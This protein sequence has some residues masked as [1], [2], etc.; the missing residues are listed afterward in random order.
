MIL[1]QSTMKELAPFLAVALMLCVAAVC[2]DRRRQLFWGRSLGLRLLPL[3]V[4]SGMAR[5]FV[6]ERIVLAEQKQALEEESTY[7]VGEI[8]GI[9]EKESW[10]VLLLR[11]VG[12]EA[13]K[14]RYLQVYAERADAAEKSETGLAGQPVGQVA[15]KEQTSGRMPQSDHPDQTEYRIGDVVRVWGEFTQFQPASNPGEFDYASYYRGQ[16][17]IWRVFA[18]AVRK[19]E[20]GEGLSYVLPNGILRVRIWAA[21][22][23]RLLAGEEDGSIFAAM[24]LGDKSGMSE[25]IRD[26]YQKNGIAHLLAVSGLH[27]SLVSMAAYGLLRK[28]GAGYGRAAVAGGVVLI[29]YSILTGASPSVIRALIMTLC[30]FLAAW[31]GRTYDLLSAMGLSA[32]ML[33][34]HSPYLI[35]QAGV[36]L[37]FA[38]IGGIGLAKEL[39]EWGAVWAEKGTESEKTLLFGA[40][41]EGAQ[42]WEQTLRLTLCMQLVSLPVVLW[43]FFSYPLYGIFLNLLV[44]PLTGIIVGSGAGSLLASLFAIRAGTF[45]TGGGRAV[46]AWYEICCRWFLRLPG[47]SLL[48]G[49]PELSERFASRFGQDLADRLEF[50]TING[51]CARVI[52]YY[53]RKTARTA[54]SLLTDEKRIS[55]ILS[56][57]Y[58]KTERV[59]PTE[60]DLKN[61]RTLITY[62]KNRMLN[63]KEIEAL[64]ET[65]EIRISAIYKEYCK[66]L[67]ENQLMDYDDQMVYAYNMLRK[68]PW[69]LEYF[70]DQYP[71][72]CVDEAQDTSKIQHAIIALLASRTE[73]LFM[74]GDEDQSIYGFRAAYPEALLEFEQH[75]PGANVLLMEENFRSDANIV[76]AA[77]SF[78]QK[79]TLRHEKH[80]RPSRPKQRELREISVANRKAQ[81][82]YLLKVAARVHKSDCSSLPGS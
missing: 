15:E 36:Q 55:A 31:L 19:V 7:G 50:R 79:N 57:I 14:L 4:V 33:L 5:G 81:Y 18:L 32:L 51:I 63:E 23:L 13:G 37:S 17:L 69:L 64:D 27:L 42:A 47:S 25:E 21:A 71:Y 60:G 67:R 43:H 66:H 46:L 70:Q 49:R 12:T 80:M 41:G 11:D 48:R 59:Y 53:G 8:C 28:A 72:I 39:E 54:F 16:K 3:F 56:A 24:L 29:L 38:A 35:D 61:V 2:A 40:G 73:N 9:T 22:R 77:D 45:L 75:H 82:S 74:V 65:A 26:L 44:V 76:Q 58:Q 62:I 10:S 34:W 6:E 30:G 78:I 1:H 20:T 68:I 52:Q